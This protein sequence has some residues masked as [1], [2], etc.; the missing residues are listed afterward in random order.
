[1]AKENRL[2]AMVKWLIQWFQEVWQKAGVRQCL[3]GVAIFLTLVGILVANLVP[4]QYDLKV[5]QVSPRDIEASRTIENRY[6]TERLRNEAVEAALEKARKDPDSYVIDEKV[7]VGAEEKLAFLFERAANL[8]APEEMAVPGVPSE[9]VPRTPSTSFSQRVSELQTSLRQEVDLEVDKQSVETL[10]SAP[11]DTF[12]AMEQAAKTLAIKMLRNNRIDQENRNEMIERMRE[13]A[14]EYDIPGPAQET[15]ANIVKNVIRPNLV[16]DT[17][18]LELVKR[19]AAQGVTPVMVLQGEIVV[20]KGDV[21]TREKLQILKDLGLQK[22]T[23]NY[24]RMFGVTWVVLILMALVGIFL[25]QYDR[26]IIEDEG[27]LALL[28]L[29]VIIVVFVIKVLSLI[30]WQGTG[31]LMPIAFGAMLIT[32]LLDSRLAILVTVALAVMVGL[33]TGGEL[34]YVCVALIGGIAS[35]LSLGKVTQRS[36]VTRVGFIVGAAN[37]VTMVAFAFINDEMFLAKNSYLGLINGIIS[38][39]FTIGFL[40][41]LENLFGITSSIKLLELSNPNQPLLRRLLLEAPGTYHHSIIVGNLAE[42]AA[43]A[44]NADGLLA[45]V[46]AAYHDVGKVRRPYFFVEN[47]LG[48]DNPHDRISPSLSTLI[49]TSHVK[50]GVEL[51]KQY[52]LPAM[53][54]DFIRQH[55]G[56][57]LVKFFYHKALEADQDGSVDE[58]DYRYP[59]P[60]PQSKETAIVMLADSVEAAVRALSRPTP[61]KIEGLVRKIIRSR[62]NDGQLDESDLTLRDLDKVAE[63]FVQVLSGIYH[64]RIEYPDLPKADA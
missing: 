1:M 40:P 60:K 37:F 23:A 9:L 30:P 2:R 21:I 32:L 7:V 15:V 57:D 36:D 55:H 10:L 14:A 4:L 29:I 62:L 3:L 11:V 53:L 41:Y 49:I 8:R 56:S 59:G 48:G 24:G 16:L 35:I 64:N 47:Q 20:R 13:Q 27:L 33:V 54:T 39:I 6:E 50:E 25:W 42:A 5:G 52:R 51:A 45:R 43:E 46:G 38:A 31:Y 61:G 19:D 28:G 12:V 17:E 26:E 22:R 34:K 18:K 58:T 44:V 63:A